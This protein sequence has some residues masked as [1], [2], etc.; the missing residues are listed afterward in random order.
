MR[1]TCRRHRQPARHRGAT[2][3]EGYDGRLAGLRDRHPETI[4]KM[5]QWVARGNGSLNVSH[6][7][8]TADSAGRR[9][10]FSKNERMLNKLSVHGLEWFVDRGMKPTDAQA[11]S[12]RQH[13]HAPRAFRDACRAKGVIVARTSAFEKNPRPHLPRHYWKR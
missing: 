2:F 10:A 11:N 9:R 3:F 13:R 7:R 12:C 5:R 4:K 1:P 8:C 6:G